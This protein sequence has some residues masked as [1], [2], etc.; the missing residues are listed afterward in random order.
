MKRSNCN[1]SLGM[2][3][4]LNLRTYPLQVSPACIREWDPAF[5]RDPA[6]ISTIYLDPRLVS[7]TWRLCGTRLLS[8]VLRYAPMA[9]SFCAPNV[10]SWLCPW[11]RVTSLEDF[12]TSKWP[13]S[14]TALVPPLYFGFFIFW[15]LTK[16][17]SFITY[18][19]NGP[20]IIHS[21]TVGE[22]DNIDYYS[23][24]AVL[25]HVVRV[26]RRWQTH[27]TCCCG[28]RKTGSLEFCQDQLHQRWASAGGWYNWQPWHAVIDTAVVT[29]S[30]RM[31]HSTPRH[32]RKSS[33]ARF[34]ASFCPEWIRATSLTLWL[35]LE[36]T[37]NVVFVCANSFP[38]D[39]HP[40][41]ISLSVN[42][43]EQYF[44]NCSMAV[45]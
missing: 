36:F 14:F 6:S 29:P 31:S 33:A 2:V 11:L 9:L 22:Y 16:L 45:R 12:L 3:G 8:E 32:R 40:S 1:V 24:Y 21:I 42:A 26:W 25:W 34:A 28:H 44:I 35:C 13:G 39:Q 15:K 17:C 37:V 43:F 19:W 10:K 20:R 27:C 23:V 5:I 7:G 41:V 18:L 4:R 38:I 30:H